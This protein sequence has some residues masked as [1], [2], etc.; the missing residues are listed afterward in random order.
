MFPE[1]IEGIVDDTV[2][3]EEPVDQ[4]SVI[5]GLQEQIT[6]MQ[7]QQTTSAATLKAEKD[8]AIDQFSQAVGFIEGS[9]TGKYDRETGKIMKIIPEQTGPDPMEVLQETIKST[10]KEIMKQFKD[11]D[12]T[13][14]EYYEQIQDNVAPLKE[15]Y[16]DMQYDHKLNKAIKSITPETKAPE[17]APKADTV[18][19]QAYDKMAEEYPDVANTDSQLF[20]KMNE[21]YQKNSSIY[22]NASYNNGQGNPD[23]FRDLIERAS[24][25]LRADGVDVKKQQAS[26]RNQ[27]ATPGNT[28]YQAP[29]RTDSNLSKQQLGMAISQGIN[30]KSLLSEINSAVGGWENTGS[31]ELED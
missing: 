27:F 11:G 14:A 4:G 17:N 18:N 28:G 22:P 23:Q 1:G 26:I 12:I 7:A 6:T 24:T 10:E 2:T 30:S 29:T 8:E 25:A 31:M 21:I 19:A 16:R 15:N 3:E 13:Q 9:G 20:K 5:A